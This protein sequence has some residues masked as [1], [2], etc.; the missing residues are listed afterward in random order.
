MLYIGFFVLCF[1]VFSGGRREG[2]GG[3][4]GVGGGRGGGVGVKCFCKGLLIC[5]L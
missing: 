2:G 1:L 5:L 4:V 3:G